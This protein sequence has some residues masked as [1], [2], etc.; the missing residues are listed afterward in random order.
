LMI[1]DFDRCTGVLS[2]P[3]R[4]SW[5]SL[6]FAGGGV[7]TSPNSRYLYLT[8]GGDVQQ[9]D[10][11]APDLVASKQIVAVYDGTMAPF[12]TTFFQMLPAPDGKIYIVASYENHVLHVI[13]QP[14]LPGLACDVAQHAVDLPALTAYFFINFANYNLGPLDPPCAIVPST[15]APNPPAILR[16]APN[17]TTGISI[18]ELPPVDGGVFTVYHTHGHKVM[19]QTVAPLATTASLD[20]QPLAAGLYWVVLTDEAGKVVAAGKVVRE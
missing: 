8:S 11:W 5:D 1:Y 16:I 15:A 18:L 14:D 13:N 6:P 9:Y 19:A 12:L 20:F 7:A 17:P 10:L 4:L 3:V 2:N